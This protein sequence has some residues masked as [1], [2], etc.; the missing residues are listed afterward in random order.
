M[1]EVNVEIDRFLGYTLIGKEEAGIDTNCRVRNDQCIELLA[2]FDNGLTSQ[3]KPQQNSLYSCTK[4]L[5]P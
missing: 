5:V 4:A 1:P 3:K 2:W